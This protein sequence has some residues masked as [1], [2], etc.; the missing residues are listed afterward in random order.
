MFRNR[1]NIYKTEYQYGT[2]VSLCQYFS[3]QNKNRIWERIEVLP[4]SDNLAEFC[5]Q[6][7]LNYENF[8]KSYQ[9]NGGPPDSITLEKIA[10]HFRLNLSW[11]ITGKDS[12][13]PINQIVGNKLKKYRKDK[14]WSIE[15]F[16]RHLSMIPQVLKYY[17][18]GSW[19]ITSDLLSNLS[20]KMKI[21]PYELIKEEISVPVQ[22]PE[23]KVFQPTSMST[24]PSI[25]SED[26]VSIPLTNSS[27]AAGQ[28]IIQENNI[29]DYVLLHI[30]AAGKRKNLVASRVDG[31]SMEPMLHSGDIVVIDREDK[32]L[33]KNRIFAIFHEGGLTAKYLEQ[34]QNLLILRPIN[35]LSQVQIINLDENQNPIVGRVIRAWKEL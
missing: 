27:I 20:E 17:E 26:Y 28:P 2:Y 25:K 34:Q 19:P 24:A 13:T 10:N 33:T 14:N 1:D 4:G 22:T 16:G 6:V 8:R 21:P 32:K 35:P 30:R 18:N 3:M 12:L 11:L 9:R 31:E 7:G 29:E 23:L 5:R 15:E